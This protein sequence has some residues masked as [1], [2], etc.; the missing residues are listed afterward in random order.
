[1]VMVHVICH[2]QMPT[3]FWCSGE[4]TISRNSGAAPIQQEPASAFVS[5]VFCN[6][7]KSHQRM[8]IIKKRRCVVCCS[9]GPDTLHSDP[10]RHT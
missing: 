9:H 3:V 5:W 7:P 6:A 1:M 2:G 8:P 4:D 10:H